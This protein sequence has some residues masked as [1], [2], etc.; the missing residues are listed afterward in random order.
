MGWDRVDGDRVVAWYKGA[1]SLRAARAVRF[2]DA[3]PPL[4]AADE[5]GLVAQVWVAPDKEAMDSLVGGG[6][7]EWG[8]ALA[9]PAKQTIIIPGRAA[10]PTTPVEEVRILRHEW[11]HLALAHELGNVRIPRWFNE[12]YAEWASGGW[13]GGGAWKLRVAIALGKAPDLDSLSLSWPRGR[14]ASEVAY[15]LSASVLDYL[16]DSSG[17]SGLEALF[18]EWKTSGSFDRALRRVYGATPSQLESDWRKYVKRRYGWLM[19]VSHSALFWAIL[20][21][22][23]LLA[24]LLRRRDKIEAMGRL[25]AGEP[26]DVPAYWEEVVPPTLPSNEG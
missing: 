10:W 1:D 23:L 20:T 15:L 16:D 26:P 17:T 13:A 8:A 14:G 7:P 5:T 21:G 22:A 9:I 2:L 12:G 11:A 3:L 19:V 4:P 6:V 25:R 24:G 18:R